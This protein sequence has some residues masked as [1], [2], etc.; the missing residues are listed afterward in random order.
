MQTPIPPTKPVP[1]TPPTMNG[2]SSTTSTTDAHKSPAPAPNPKSTSNTD[3]GT[4]NSS[5]SP[6]KQ[7]QS[8]P[9]K[10]ST[11]E[12]PESASPADNN[13]IPPV[14]YLS[15]STEPSQQTTTA[16]ITPSFNNKPAPSIGLSFILPFLI[17]IAVSFFVLRWWKKT[18]IKQRTILN[19]S[20]DTSKD[21][22]N[23]MNS[24]INADSLQKPTSKLIRKPK[25]QKEP[26]GNFEIRI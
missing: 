13:Q 26:K 14:P 16:P 12:K 4:S 21:L 1:P 3:A 7:P 17:V 5:T 24:Q 23:L 15:T 11:M 20:T 6:E 9:V 18:A 19:Y 10:T 22:L 2:T 25:T 8:Q